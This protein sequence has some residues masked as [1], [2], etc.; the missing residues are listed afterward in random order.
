MGD[1]AR[2]GLRF[3]GVFRFGLYFT[4]SLWATW[5]ETAL[6]SAHKREAE[7]RSEGAPSLGWRAG[8]PEGALGS[9]TEECLWSRSGDPRDEW[10]YSGRLGDRRGPPL[11]RWRRGAALPPENRPLSP[12]ASDGALRGW[13]TGRHGQGGGAPERPS[14][15]VCSVVGSTAPWA[16]VKRPVWWRDGYSAGP[17][18]AV[19]LRVCRSR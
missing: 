6:A 15:A 8:R 3:G 1:L 9:E 13:W 14:P 11:G 12:P 2:A 7:G 18:S 16:S 10:D 4:S 17:G 5:S 19:L